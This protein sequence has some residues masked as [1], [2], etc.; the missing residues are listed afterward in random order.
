M[1]D[2]EYI[3]KE[4]LLKDGATKFGRYWAIPANAKKPKNRRVTTGEYRNWRRSPEKD[5]E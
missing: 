5:Y 2:F 4:L 1:L 3:R